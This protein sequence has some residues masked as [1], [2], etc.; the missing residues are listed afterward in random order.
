MLWLVQCRL[1]SLLASSL[2]LS[3]V[4][5]VHRQTTHSALLCRL[6]TAVLPRSIPLS[7]V[8]PQPTLLV[9]Y[10]PLRR[11]EPPAV[12]PSA[13]LQLLFKARRP[14]RRDRLP[15]PQQ[16]PWSMES[17]SPLISKRSSLHWVLLAPISH[18]QVQMWI[19]SPLASTVPTTF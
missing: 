6:R 5:T 1:T 17:R 16:S 9:L 12:H 15:L 11:Q 7:A 14:V 8:P 19:G 2:S 3:Q 18:F 10:P 13:A 4:R